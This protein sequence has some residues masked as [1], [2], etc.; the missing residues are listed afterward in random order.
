MLRGF[1]PADYVDCTDATLHCYIRNVVSIV[2]ALQSVTDRLSQAK[3]VL[4][5]LDSGSGAYSFSYKAT[6]SKN[7][8][9]GH[10][11]PGRLGC[12]VP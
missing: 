8:D 12:F 11:K 5:K 4:K 10:W 3:L 6:G 2:G 9:D 1:D 7:P